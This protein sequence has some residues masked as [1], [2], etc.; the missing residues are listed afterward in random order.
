MIPYFESVEWMLKLH[1][2]LPKARAAPD[3]AAGARMK[4]KGWRMNAECGKRSIAD[5]CRA[6]AAS[7]TDTDSKLSKEGK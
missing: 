5:A 2:D 7:C 1:K 4:A 6:D 3:R